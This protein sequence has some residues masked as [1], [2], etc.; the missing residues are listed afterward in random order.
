[1]KAQFFEKKISHQ[2]I[3][4]AAESLEIK[5]K[6]ALCHP[7]FIGW[8]EIAPWFRAQLILLAENSLASKYQPYNTANMSHISC[9]RDISVGKYLFE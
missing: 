9:A 5:N 7:Y 2:F 3:D 4:Q 6:T 8:C 1:M